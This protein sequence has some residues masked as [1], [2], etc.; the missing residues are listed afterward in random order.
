[1]G[2][3]AYQ[4]QNAVS[5][6]PY[7]LILKLYEGL[8]KYLS[9]VKSA[10]ENGDVEQKFTY[11]NKSIAIFDEL[12]NVLDFD[13]GDVA[14]YLDGLY[15]YQIETLFSAGIDDNINSI[16]QVMKVTQGLID[17]W[18]DETGL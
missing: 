11:I 4:Q 9:F 17:A 1:M 7:V 18:K 14:Y 6:D 3:E 5:D 2:I 10:M 12:R 16:N 13:G 15:L 8:L